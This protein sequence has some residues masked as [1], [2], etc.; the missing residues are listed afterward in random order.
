MV[1]RRI[2]LVVLSVAL[3]AVGCGGEDSSGEEAGGQYDNG[4]Q[5]ENGPPPTAASESV[6][7]QECLEEVSSSEPADVRIREPEQPPDYAIVDESG[8][9]AGKRLE[10][11]SGAG[12]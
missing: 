5:Y 11:V 1:L 4:Q 6:S 9:E 12:R 7:A 8:M 2:I 3:F 10:G